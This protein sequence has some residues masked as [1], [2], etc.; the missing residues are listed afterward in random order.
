MSAG[1][2]ST[3]LLTRGQLLRLYRHRHEVKPTRQQ[4]KHILASMCYQRA[5][6]SPARQNELGWFWICRCSRAQMERIPAIKEELHF[7]EARRRGRA[8]PLK[9]RAKL[10][11]RLQGDFASLD[12][13]LDCIRALAAHKNKQD[14]PLLRHLAA[15]VSFPVC[16]AL[17]P[18]LELF[19]TPQDV[20]LLFELGRRHV[21]DALDA[22]VKLPGHRAVGAIRKL[23]RE[24][25]E[26]VRGSL[27]ARLADWRNPAALGLLRRLA[28]DEDECV[29]A[30]AASS[31]GGLRRPEDL[32]LLRRMRQDSSAEVRREAVWAIGCYRRED[33][34]TILKLL[35][36]DPCVKMRT[37]AAMTLARVLPRREMERWL[38]QEGNRMSF[39]LLLEL[40]F[41]IYAPKWVRKAH[42]RVGDN[43]GRLHLGRCRPEAG[44]GRSVDGNSRRADT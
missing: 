44:I 32:P 18:A 13:R 36:A 2:T 35:A 22:L 41:A 42:S 40:D 20:D 25:N 17:G 3:K 38:D 31:L 34:I 30:D 7:I 8:R 16:L 37:V 5:G 4:L 26:C 19:R 23:A 11:R 12:E 10:L 33:D 21:F 14:L 27:A 43:I 1:R 39:E 9:D 24:G 15:E 29:R 6:E 28:Q